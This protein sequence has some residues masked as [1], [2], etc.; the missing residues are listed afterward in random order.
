MFTVIGNLGKGV[1]DELMCD[2]VIMV[3]YGLCRAVRREL[4][5]M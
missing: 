2:K 3:D 4:W 5:E 1:C